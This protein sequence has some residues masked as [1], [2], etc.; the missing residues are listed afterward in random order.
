MSTREL[1]RREFGA[2]LAGILVAFS[3]APAMSVAAETGRGLPAMLAAN[4]RLDAWLRID[5]LG[6]VTVYTGR[7]ELGQGNLTAL[8]Q[9]VAEE[10]DI[11]L[12]RVRMIQPGYA[13]EYD[14]VDPRNLS[15]TLETKAVKG[16][17]LAGQI[18]GTTG[19][20]EAAAQGLL[21]GINAARLAGDQS[22]IVLDRAESYMGVLVDDLTTALNELRQE[23][24]ALQINKIA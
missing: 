15:A 11:A 1:S 21:A 17:F 7:V 5:P 16:L 13:I 14:F 9:I 20:E 23:E 24:P 22:G 6:T 10:L 3:M 4:R 19:Y 2:G 8:A 18:N 12:E